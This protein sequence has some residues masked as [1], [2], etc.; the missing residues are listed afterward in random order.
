MMKIFAVLSASLLLAACGELRAPSVPHG[1]PEVEGNNEPVEPDPPVDPNAPPPAMPTL[2]ILPG[3]YGYTTIPVRGQG[4][5]FDTVFVEGGKAPVATDSDPAGN[6][7][8]DVPLLDGQSHRLEVYVQDTRGE[9]SEPAE[10]VVAHDP[11]LAEYVVPEQP[12][13]ALAGASPVYSD[14]TAKEGS[15]E[16]L[17]DED[18][19]TDVVVE[20]SYV[21]VDLGDLYDI[22]TI[23]LEFPDEA[24]AGNDEFATEYQV[25]ASSETAPLIPPDYDDDSWMIIYDIFPGSYIEG[26]DGGIDSFEL[27]TP[28]RARYVS[29][30]LIENNKT[31]WFSSES[32]RVSEI[33][34]NGRA[35]NQLPAEPLTPTCAN[36]RMP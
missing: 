33:S 34:I 8:V 1:M 23:E 27:P 9:T 7:C 15:F 5:P 25:L 36:G 18:P 11:G 4:T 19:T 10:V 13:A 20:K 3:A 12:L 26:G 21:W 31:D 22:E 14:A 2:S 29:F 24:G 17:T 32:I 6:F 16:N 30:Y 28:L 35:I